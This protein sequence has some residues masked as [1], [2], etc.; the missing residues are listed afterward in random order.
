MFCSLPHFKKV[1]VLNSE[2]MFGSVWM[3]RVHW[4]VDSFLLVINFSDFGETWGSSIISQAAGT[5]SVPEP[6][7][8]LHGMSKRDWEYFRTHTRENGL[9]PHLP[10]TEGLHSNQ[11]THTEKEGHLSQE[12]H[13]YSQP[14][15]K[16]RLMQQIIME[17][18]EKGL[19]PM[20]LLNMRIRATETAVVCKAMSIKWLC[21]GV[22]LLDAI[23]AWESFKFEMYLWF[24]CGV[25][26][27]LSCW[28]LKWNKNIFYSDKLLATQP[29]SYTNKTAWFAK[30]HHLHLF[31]FHLELLCIKTYFLSETGNASEPVS[32]APPQS[33]DNSQG[34]L[35]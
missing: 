22:F 19:S 33:L 1:Q 21:L 3:C 7:S 30:M 16:V 27:L 14:G 28:L 4:K 11:H 29:Q 18:G 10:C 32:W 13:I 5:D 25:R 6:D 9:Y 12:N 23:S 26:S 15:K 20:A 31:L 35:Q 17:R 8:V 34:T 24:C 2:T